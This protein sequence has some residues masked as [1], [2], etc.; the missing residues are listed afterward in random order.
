MGAHLAILQIFRI[1]GKP[2]GRFGVYRAFMLCAVIV[3]FTVCFHSYI[4]K[5]LRSRKLT[6]IIYR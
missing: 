4:F 3:I 6:E 1:P 5:T 2:L